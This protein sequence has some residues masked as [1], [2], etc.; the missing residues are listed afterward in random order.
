M[1]QAWSGP[2][3][4]AVLVGLELLHPS[5]CGGFTLALITLSLTIMGMSGSGFMVFWKLPADM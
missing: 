2:S 1:A 4:W 5:F 3:P